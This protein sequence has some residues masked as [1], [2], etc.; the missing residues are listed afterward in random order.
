MDECVKHIKDLR[1]VIA[2]FPLRSA[3][4]A[5]VCKFC[6]QV[7]VKFVLNFVDVMSEK[8]RVGIVVAD[9]S[10]LFPLMNSFT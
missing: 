5:S 8:P 10:T 1:P 2:F 7:R 4:M 6:V 3:A 9:A